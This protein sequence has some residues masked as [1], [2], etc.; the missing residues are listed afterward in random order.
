MKQMKRCDY[1]VVIHWPYLGTREYGA[2]TVKS[3]LAV[4]RHVRTAWP[5]AVRHMYSTGII[6]RVWKDELSYLTGREPV[7]YVRREGN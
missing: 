2:S 5:N 6:A 1:T 3:A 7:A 4:F